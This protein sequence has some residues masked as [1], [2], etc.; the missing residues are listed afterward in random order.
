MLSSTLITLVTTLLPFTLAVPPSHR[1]YEIS[2]ICYN[3]EGVK[4][5]GYNKAHGGDPQNITVADIQG[6]AAY[7]R[8]YGQETSPGR[9]FTMTTANAADCAEWTLATNGTAL[10]LAKHLNSTID[11]S[12]LFEDIA[13]TIDGGE[14]ATLTNNSGIVSCLKDGGSLGVIVNQTADAYNTL[15]YLASGAYMEGILIKIVH[16]K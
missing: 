3:G 5:N 13:N 16:P 14:N 7:L 10:A 12:V 6:V 11:S 9:L 8:S 1:S 2:G 15:D 4:L